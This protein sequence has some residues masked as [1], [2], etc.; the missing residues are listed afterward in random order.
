M[1]E[2]KHLYL[3]S[4]IICAALYFVWPTVHTMALRNLLLLGA[5]VVGVM[6]WLRDTER[7]AIVSS[8]WLMYSGLLLAWVIFHAAFISQNGNEAWRELLGQWLLPYLAMLAGIGLAL[9]SRSISP[10]AFRFYLLAMLAS[11][12][13][14]YLF[15]TLIKSAQTGHLTMGTSYWGL[16][17]HK[18]SLTFYADLMAAG[19]CA[20][21]I[22][23]VKSG[24]A[25]SRSFLWLLPV[26]LAFYV[27]IF[28][29]SLN[30]LILVSGC[31]M[32][33]V[34]ILIYL[35]WDKIPKSALAVAA[36]LLVSFLF[37]LASSSYM[38]AKRE[39]L[40]GNTRIAVN[41]DTYTNWRNFP[42]VALPKDEQ[43]VQ[44]KESYYL[45]IAYAT[46]GLRTII[47][48]PW[49]YGVTRHAFERLIQ[50]QHPDA[51]I[52]N[53]HNAYID[54]LTAVGFPALL[55]LAMMNIS[56]YRQLRHSPSEWARP[57]AW[58]IGI[59][60]V[61]WMLDPISRDHYFD[62]FLFLI[63]LFSTL[64]LISRQDHV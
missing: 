58:M 40:L 54:L 22:D 13:V 29:D 6:L 60:L 7:K 64:T 43:G 26:A 33:T 8:T 1:N 47:E 16:T 12:S 61:H 27:A 45:R 11:Q 34:I 18:M 30:G 28:A 3:A 63:G 9:A 36:L 46:A 17:D 50:Q 52:A 38:V 24:A 19:A 37:L 23:E 21:I 10:R 31:L 41:I 14:F 32:L 56:L 55:L 20:K 39:M 42:Q 59:I 35:R 2:T 44:V 15:Y 51:T 25:S 4:L 48:H 53:S 5:F 57:A 62:T 49:G